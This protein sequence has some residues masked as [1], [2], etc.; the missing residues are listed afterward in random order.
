MSKFN[1]SAATT[2]KTVNLAGGE[3]FT[4]TPELELV[5]ALLT[6]FLEDQYYEKGTKRQSRI[7]ELV[8]KVDPKFAAQASIY[9]RN[10]F[11][12]RSVSHVVAAKIA[13]TVK[14]EQWT[15]SYFDKVVRRPDDMLEIMSLYY[16]NYGKNEPNA[17]KKGFATAIGRFDEYQLAKY[18]GAGKSVKLVDIVNLVHPAH[19]AAIQKLVNDELRNTNTFEAKLSKAGQSGEEGAKGAAWTELVESGKIGQTALLRNLRNILQESPEVVDKAI[20]LLTDKKRI[21]TS[22][23]LPFQYLTAY[24]QLEKERGASKLLGGLSKALD[25]SFVNVPKFAGRTLVVIDHSGSMGEGYGSN[26]IKAA[27]FGLSLA[28]SSGADLMHFGDNAEYLSFNPEDSTMTLLRYLDGLNKGYGYGQAG[29][30]Q[31]GHGTNFH[32]IFQEANQVYDRIVIITDMQAWMG[33]DHPGKSLASYKSR[34][35]ANPFIYG[36]DISG[37]GSLQFPERNVATLAGWSEKV[38]DIMKLV[39]TDKQALVNTIKKVEL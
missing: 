33:Y 38:F 19:S 24:E 1:T 13:G 39:E 29:T 11:G 5:T 7:E 20:K 23:I 28:R 10:E 8:D 37:Y 16:S 9:A 34:V 17:L 35:G 32:A 22:L 18:R 21:S 36:W 6:S 27:M 25:V 14:G 26:F 15:K 30:H 31:V 3:A 12:M 2:N 4:M